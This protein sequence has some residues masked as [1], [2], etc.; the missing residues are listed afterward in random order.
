MSKPKI[1][2]GRDV[3]AILALHGFIKIRQRGSHVVMQ[4]KSDES[5]KT[6]PV[7]NHDVISLGTLRST[8]RQSGLNSIR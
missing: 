5:T 7:P 4:K 2:S 1:N 8:I 3:C 6:V